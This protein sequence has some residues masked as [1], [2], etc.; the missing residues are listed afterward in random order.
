MNL[1]QGSMTRNIAGLLPELSCAAEEKKRS[2]F[3][4]EDVRGV[5]PSVP[6]LMDA[7]VYALKRSG[8]EHFD[9]IHTIHEPLV[10]P[11]TR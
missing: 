4:F 2:C 7:R 9:D 6:A 3:P 11:V 5:S 10:T 8:E 1:G